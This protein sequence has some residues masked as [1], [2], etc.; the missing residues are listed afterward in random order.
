MMKQKLMT[1]VGRICVT[2]VFFLLAIGQVHA[3]RFRAPAGLN[4]GDSYRVAFV[5]SSGRSAASSTNISVYNNWVNDIANTGST[6]TASLGVNWTVIGSTVAVNAFDN[7]NTIPGTDGSGIPIFNTIGD[8]IADSYSDLWDGSLD[9][10][11]GYTQTGAGLST[12]VFTGSFPNGSRY[13]GYELGGGGPPSVMAGL[14]EAF[15]SPWI[16]VQTRSNSEQW[17]M[18]GLSEQITVVPIPASILLLGSGL[19]ALA[20]FRRQGRKA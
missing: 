2:L 11:V 16:T 12:R 1:M 15:G 3:A 20:G 14:S 13:P 17:P 5:T 6:L 7:T 19:V 10:P 8:K 9:F 4:P 18:Y